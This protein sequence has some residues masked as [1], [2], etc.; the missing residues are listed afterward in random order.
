MPTAGEFC[1]RRTIVAKGG[2]TISDIAQRMRDEHVGSVVVVEHLPGSHAVP[3][4]VL[5]DRDIVVRVLA[6]TDRHLHSFRVRDIMTEKLIKARDDEDLF[7]VLKRMRSF[8]IRRIPIVDRSERLQGIITLDDIVDFL[9]EQISNM[10]SLISRERQ[11][12][13]H[14]EAT[15]RCRHTP[16]RADLRTGR[17]SERLFR[18]SRG[19]QA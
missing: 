3:V 5:T 10:S 19:R 13:E 7:E 18:T 14:P 17:S 12:E 6:A 8:G 16:L 2:E 15:P 9:H 1:N 4:G 11:R